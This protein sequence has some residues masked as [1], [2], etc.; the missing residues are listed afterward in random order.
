[1]RNHYQPI[2]PRKDLPYSAFKKRP[3]NNI[4]GMRIRVAIDRASV[5]SPAAEDI[6]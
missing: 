1:M 2:S 4:K 5:V 6:R 3:L